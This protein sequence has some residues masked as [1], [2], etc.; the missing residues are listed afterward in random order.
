MVKKSATALFHEECKKSK[1]EATVA[2]MDRMTE[3]QESYGLLFENFDAF[4]AWVAQRK[5]LSS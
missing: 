5:A 3:T 1:R 4:E 2:D